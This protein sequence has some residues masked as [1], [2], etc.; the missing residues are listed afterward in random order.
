MAQSVIVAGATYPDVPS[1]LLPKTGGGNAMFVDVTATTATADKILSGYG[2]YGSDGSWING[3]HVDTGVSVTTTQDSGGGDIVTITSA[4]LQ[5]LRRVLMRPDVQKVVTHSYDKFINADEGVTIPSYTT[6]SQTLKASS[7]ISETVSMDLANYNYYILERTFSYPVYSISTTGKGRTEYCIGSAMYEVVEFPANTFQALVNTTKHGSRS[8]SVYS[9]G[10]AS[11]IVY[12]SGA[13]TLTAASSASYGTAQTITA[14][15][16]ASVT[17]TTLTLK[18]PAFITRG[19]TTYYTSAYM[20]AVTDIR[21]Q[22]VIDVY[23]APKSNLAFDGWGL[24]G[25]ACD[26]LDCVNSPTHK[27]V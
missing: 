3:T 14:P 27:L 16:I 9:A 18:T 21:Y 5:P 12:W 11:R 7:D 8:T 13:S 2:A 10:N 17:S 15:A 25:Q 19:S 20:N 23:R 6:T 22:W 24:Y 4:T 1:V 26:I